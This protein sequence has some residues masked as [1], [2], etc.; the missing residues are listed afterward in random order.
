MPFAQAQ[1]GIID[2]LVVDKIMCQLNKKAP[3]TRRVQESEF[4]K[5]VALVRLSEQDMK[6]IEKRMVET[7]LIT[8]KGKVIYF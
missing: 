8:R 1:N 7:G 6:T 4:K 2:E 5:T 3:L